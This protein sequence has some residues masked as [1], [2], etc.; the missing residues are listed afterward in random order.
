MTG[1]ILKSQINHRDRLKKF[2]T[3]KKRGK[4]MNLKETTKKI[5]YIFKG[6]IINLRLDDI[7]LPNNK[8]ATREVVEHPGGVCVAALTE[9]NH[10]LL[11]N[12]YRY[13]YK[14]E[15]LEL[16]AGKLSPGEDPLQCAKRELQEETGATA[17]DFRFLGEL[18]PSPGYCEEIIHIYF[19]KV[20]AIGAPQPD[21]DEFLE[22]KQIPLEEALD[23]VLKG[24]V[25]DA[26]TQTAILKVFALKNRGEL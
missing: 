24:E 14:K 21:A 4:I 8:P 15:V 19:A 9:Q 10:L 25:P 11:V 1:K 6:N 22:V 26:K 2:L 18:Y 3:P 13:P 23:M 5:T 7:E 17:K 20:S 12:Q 16:P